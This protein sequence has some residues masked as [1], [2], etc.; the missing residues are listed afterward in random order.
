ME[1]YL[2]EDLLKARDEPELKSSAL[3]IAEKLG[4]DYFCYALAYR[5]DGESDP[6]YFTLGNYPEVWLDRYFNEGYVNIDPSALHCLNSTL[7]VIWTHKLFDA[8]KVVDMHH[9]AGEIGIRGG[10]CLPIHSPWL[11]GAGLLG[12][13]NGEDTDKAVPHVV[14]RLGASQLFAC[15][16][17]EAARKLLL[18]SDMAFEQTEELT[19]RELECLRWA[20]KGLQA[21]QIADRMGISWTVLIKSHSCR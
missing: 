8:R 15:Y 13:A 19:A 20:A 17:N 4:Y 5:R 3:R 1:L 7:P 21:K 14:D 12:L 16:L 10:V 11:N 2:F 6:Q 18:P 9:E